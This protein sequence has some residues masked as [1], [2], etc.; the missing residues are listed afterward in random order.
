MKGAPRPTLLVR[1]RRS[2]NARHRLNA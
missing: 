1:S 2:G